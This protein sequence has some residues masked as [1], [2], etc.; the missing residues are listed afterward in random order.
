M[1]A[2]LVVGVSFAIALGL[3]WTF[4]V[5]LVGR[6]L[7]TMEAFRPPY[8][9][10]GKD[11]KGFNLG[12]R[13]N[14]LQVFGDNWKLWFLPVFTTKGDGIIWPTRCDST[15]MVRPRIPIRSLS[16]SKVADSTWTHPETEETAS[17]E[18]VQSVER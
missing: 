13:I 5:S 9:A 6:N 3:L 11:K 18:S 14:F 7:T 8:F 17:T 2:V 4:H 10:Y 12:A 16:R 1:A 15:G